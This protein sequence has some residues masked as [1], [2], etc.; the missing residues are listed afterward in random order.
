MLALPAAADDKRQFQMNFDG[1]GL[2]QF[3][4]DIVGEDRDRFSA[5]ERRFCAVFPEHSSIKLRRKSGFR[6]PS[7]NVDQVSRLDAAPGKGL[8]FALAGSDQAI[9]ASQASD[10]VLIVLAYLALLY[11]PRQ[12]RM[13]LIEEPENGIH[14]KRLQDVITILRELVQEQTTTQILMTTHSPYLLD[15]FQ[16]DEVT[17]CTKDDDGAVTL[18]RLSDSETVRKQIGLFNLGE[19]WTSEGESALVD[20]GAATSAG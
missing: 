10:G 12:P 8:Y 2:A 9:P 11:S 4:D 20:E 14:P 6:A 17:V 19:I 13:L 5:L 16:P 18:T 1:F 15:L 7:D 3:L